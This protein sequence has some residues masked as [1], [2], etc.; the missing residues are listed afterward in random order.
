M[1]KKGKIAEIFSKAVYIDDPN[2]YTIGYIDLGKVKEVALPEFL[3][4]SENF[5]VIPVTRISYIKKENKKLYSKTINK[6][7]SN[8]N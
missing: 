5:E 1:A 6:K 4:L 7:N 8:E 3:K 2:L